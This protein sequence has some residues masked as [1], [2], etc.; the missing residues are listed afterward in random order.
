MQ[1]PVPATVLSTP[2]DDDERVA[3]LDRVGAV[4]APPEA[5]LDGLVRLAARIC[6]TSSAEINLV[7]AEQLWFCAARGLGTPG[8]AV[9]R[10]LTFCTWTILD[11]DRPLLV[12]DARA[13][14]RFAANPF[15]TDGT[16]GSYAGFP[17][18]AE[19]HA[20]G[21]MCVH[22]PAPRT[23]DPDQLDALAVLATAAQT[24]LGLRRHVDALSE[25][26]RTDALTG[27]ANRRAMDEV[28]ERE[29][30]RS[31]RSGAPVAVVMLDMDGF[32]GY[33]DE[34]G[35]PAGDVLLQRSAT[36]WRAELRSGDLLGRWGGEEFCVLLADCHPAAALAVADRLRAAVPEGRTCSAGVACWDGRETVDELIG[37]VDAAL[38]DAKHA[39]RDRTAMA[40]KLTATT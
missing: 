22:D 8:V 28:L 25:L 3:A 40:T 11:P 24:Q 19:G 39:G 10:G 1:R 29:L 27:A 23:L 13:D 37:R 32:K 4:G 31:E 20:I 6:A 18:I 33:N 36:A 14:D 35:H 15:V 26:A 16:I 5:A 34:F 30:A 7:G 9:E 17:L 21:T 38:Y 2:S 12:S